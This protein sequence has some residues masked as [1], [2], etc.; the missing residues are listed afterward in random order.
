M[1]FA[2]RCFIYQRTYAAKDLRS[3]KMGYTALTIGAWFTLFVGVFMGTVGV[4]MLVS[5]DGEAQN[6][7]NPFTAIMEEVMNLGGFAKGAGVI[8][9]TA[10]LAAIMSTADSLVIAISQLVTVEIIY[11]LTPRSSPSQITW[12]GRLVSLLS[13]VVALCIG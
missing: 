2:S 12:C 9:V 8:A 5:E 1:P 7:A 10:S 11:P 4:N 3:M 6:P 13:A